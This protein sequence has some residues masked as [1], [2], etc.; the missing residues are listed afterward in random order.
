MAY[1]RRRGNQLVIVHG[2]REPGTGKVQQQILFTLYSKAEAREALGRGED[3]QGAQRFRGLLEREYP[4]FT[5]DWTAIQ[6]A[7]EREM[8]ALPD[9]YDHRAARI[10]NRFRA[11][12]RAFARQL[13]LVDP[14]TLLAAA[15][16]IR[17]HRYELEFL[18]EQIRWRLETCD[19]SENDWNRDNPYFW[20]FAL[21][22]R[23]VPGE[24]EELAASFYERGDH[25]RAGAVFRLLVDT[26]DGYAEGY[27]YLGLIALEQRK[28][29]EAIGHF[30]R[31]I[32]LGRRLFPR[33]LA[34]RHFWSDHRTRPY[35]RGLRNLAL[36][37]NETG[38]HEGA[39]RLCDRLE[40]E[41]GDEE[42]ATWHRAIVSLN[43]GRW[44]P[45]A[46]SAAKLAGFLPDANLLAGLALFELGRQEESVSCFLHG[47][48]NH[49]LTAR[50]LLDERTARPRSNHEIEDHNAGVAMSR[51]LQA[52]RGSRSPASR[53][54][55]RRLVRDPRVVALLDEIASVARQ[56]ELE[57]PTG[58]RT[59]FDRLH[60]MRSRAFAAAQA[61]QLGDLVGPANR[62]TTIH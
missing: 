19:Q 25:E 52:Y 49:P 27:N 22:G 54:F 48:L 62:A 37:L 43:T 23:E 26:F 6:R 42:T 14:Q 3:P 55:F 18:A 32:E 35:M 16:L 41:C 10:E 20:R 57:H 28:L 33:R 39:L 59:A 38:D 40:V 44:Q 45:A 11:D 24:V 36:T 12:L 13:I 4:Q 31:T 17:K 1:L 21:P 34:K 46:E 15:E 29:E 7:I 51:S 53:R 56:R 8:G 9:L 61:Q 30:E 58:D 60:Q 47:A 50:L 5:F 2:E